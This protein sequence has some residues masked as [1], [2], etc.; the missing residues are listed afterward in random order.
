MTVALERDGGVSLAVIDD[1]KANALSF[2]VIDGRFFPK[3]WLEIVFSPSFPYRLMH[4]V[5]AFYVTTAIVVLGV[6]A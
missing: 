4:T 5:S 3:D 1:G 2:E 6:G